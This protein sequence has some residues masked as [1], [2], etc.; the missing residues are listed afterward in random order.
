MMLKKHMIKTYQQMHD[1]IIWKMKDNW[2]I[3]GSLFVDEWRPEWTFDEKNRNWFGFQ[4][5]MVGNSVLKENDE[6]R[7]EYT[8]TDHRVYRHQLDVHKSRNI[9]GRA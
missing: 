7:T 2:D 9:M 5:G 4:F 6:L 8:W 1:F 3:Y